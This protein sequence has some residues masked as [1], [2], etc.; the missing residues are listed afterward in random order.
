MEQEKS[1]TLREQKIRQWFAMWLE[2]RDSGVASLFAPD[3][4]YIE[5]W[6]PEYHGAAKIQLWF[7]EWNRRG[8]VK[9][10]DILQFLHQENQTAVFWRFHCQ[11]DDGTEQKFDGVSLIRWT[12][13]NQIGL[14]QEFGC[15]IER[16]DPYEKGS[17]P[18]FRRQDAFWF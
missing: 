9:V 14:L 16:Y 3:A 11:M 4:V 15:H 2:K 18:V 1:R 5:S 8:Q 17:V 6:G 7:E 13:Q 12:E 10:W